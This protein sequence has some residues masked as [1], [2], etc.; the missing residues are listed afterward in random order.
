MPA[1][2]RTVRA[3]LGRRQLL[4]ALALTLLVPGAL[5]AAALTYEAPEP[6][7]T[8]D[9]AAA[10]F[11]T[12]GTGQCRAGPTRPQRRDNARGAGP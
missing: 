2:H 12:A 9:R 10:P 6:A 5:G 8:L 11:A 7:P 1:E 4:G 3:S